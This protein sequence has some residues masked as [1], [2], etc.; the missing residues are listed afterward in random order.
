MTCMITIAAN[1]KLE[2]IAIMLDDRY[3]M[4]RRTKDI[5][6]PMRVA[7][8]NQHNDSED[9]Y[10]KSPQSQTRSQTSKA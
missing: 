6:C 8:E 10:T 1:K 7:L 9:I 4:Q 2:V 3:Q 5:R